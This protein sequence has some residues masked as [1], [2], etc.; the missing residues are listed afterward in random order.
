ML[1]LKTA[2]SLPPPQYSYQPCH[3]PLNT[4]ST[5]WSLHPQEKK[6]TIQTGQPVPQKTQWRNSAPQLHL[7][8]TGATEGE[9][10]NSSNRSALLKCQ[11]RRRFTCTKVPKTA[12]TYLAFICRAGRRAGRYGHLDFPELVPV[13][14]T[15]AH[16]SGAMSH[17]PVLYIESINQSLNILY[18]LRSLSKPL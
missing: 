5:A 4:F 1:T 10:E 18:S 13:E 16:S 3:N 6:K 9:E 8:M 7:Q 2:A 17:G 11:H 15:S 12:K 14:R